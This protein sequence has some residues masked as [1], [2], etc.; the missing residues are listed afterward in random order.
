MI[1]S[2]T[3]TP[4]QFIDWLMY[5]CAAFQYVCI[6]E[7]LYKSY[8]E[9]HHVLIIQIKR[10]GNTNRNCI[11]NCKAMR[12]FKQWYKKE[13]QE[14]WPLK[15]WIWQLY[16]VNLKGKIKFKYRKRTFTDF[17]FRRKRTVVYSIYG[18]VA[19]TDICSKDI[20]NSICERTF[21]KK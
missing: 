12:I 6:C 9:K 18:V 8:K 14:Q 19:T 16:L 4:L 17:T 20:L 1:F 10:L 3:F 21:S 13:K 11:Y 2:F 5:L 15:T 7:C